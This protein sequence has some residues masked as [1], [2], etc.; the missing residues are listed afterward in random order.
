MSIVQTVYTISSDKW[1]YFPL[2][3]PAFNIP[4]VAKYHIHIPPTFCTDSD[5]IIKENASIHKI[6]FINNP[7]FFTGVQLCVLKVIVFI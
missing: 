3:V 7:Y 4:S 1:N 5:E 2:F 6:L